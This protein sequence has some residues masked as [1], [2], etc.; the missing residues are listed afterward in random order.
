M[1]SKH[2]IL[3]QSHGAKARDKVPYL[4]KN[5][6]SELPEEVTGFQFLE[7]LHCYH[8]AIRIIPDTISSLQCLNYLDLSRNQLTNLP[9]EICQL[10][11]QILLVSNNRLSCLPDELHRMSQLTELDASCNQLTHLPPRL[12][13]LKSLQSL[14]LRNNLLLAIPVE[15]TYLKLMTLDLR[16]NRISLLPLEMRE[17]ASL[18][19]LLLCKRGR[20]HI[21]KF[22]ETEATKLDRKTGGGMGTLSRRSR[23]SGAG[24]SP[25]PPHLAD[26]LKQKRQNV[27]SGY[28]TSSDCYEKRW[29]QEIVGDE[30]QQQWST[31]P[32]SVR[33]V[34]Q[35][36]THSALSTPSTISPAPDV[37]IED[38]STKISSSLSD[39]DRSDGQRDI[40]DYT[41]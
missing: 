18:I 2:N 11:I 28:S 35:N 23:K 34:D 32:V 13:D 25:G 33:S 29:S 37:G 10:P 41:R 30:K 40:K 27:D 39:Y 21:C 5:R 1:T 31:T 19:N 8:N 20:V 12:G 7:K 9:R 17:M 4:S 24:S 38:D 3:E 16:A 6:F 15:L 14:V 22:L 36:G 26:R